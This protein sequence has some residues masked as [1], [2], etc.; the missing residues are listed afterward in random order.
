MD[1]YIVPVTNFQQNCSILVCPETKKAAIVDPGGDLPR[2]IEKLKEL[3][4]MPEK[5]LVTHAHLDHAGG[6]FEL[7][8][9]LRIPIEGPHKGDQFWIDSMEQQAAMFGLPTTQ[10]FKPDRWLDQ[11]DKVTVGEQILAVAHCP[12][13]TPG[14]V[15]FF[16]EDSQL[17]IVG[18]VLFQGSIGRSDF[19][20]GDH[21]TLI[22]SIKS[23]LLPLGDDVR[24]I[25]GH[26]PMSTMGAERLS[27]PFVSGRFG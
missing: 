12:G 7:S 3:H 4:V 5:I 14:H 20:G 18:D 26:G 22:A 17:A 1:F 16:H 24:F 21:E 19:P 25:P 23:K 15:T 2:I 27:N 6:C 13:H 10:S 8:N 9:L 11:G